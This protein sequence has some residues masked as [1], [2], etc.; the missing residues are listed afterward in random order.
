MYAGT[1][2]L[3]ALLAP[4]GLN[5][6]GVADPAAWDALSP[7]ARQSAALLP[8]TRAILVFGSGGPTLWR[9]FVA[10]L[11]RHPAHL[12]HEADPLDAYVRRVVGVANAALDTEEGPPV[13]R[14]WFFAAPDEPTPLD[15]RLLAHLAGLGGRSRLGLLLHPRYGTWLGLRAACYTTAA[16]PH[17][18]P[19][20]ADPC[21]GC[22]APCVSACPGSAFPGGTWSVERCSAF[23]ATSPR[24]NDGCASRLACPAGIEERYDDAAIQYHY[25]REAGRARLR[26]HLGIPA[27]DDRHAGIGPHWGDWKERVDVAGGLDA[28]SKPGS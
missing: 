4:T 20:E 17:D 25:N 16:V 7:P 5:V 24:C 8:G 15:F 3:P 14:R 6:Y 18:A 2:D 23:H 28:P 10:D 27:S 9:Q 13:A 21:A 1:T 19:D 11:E 12:T 22:A 26:A